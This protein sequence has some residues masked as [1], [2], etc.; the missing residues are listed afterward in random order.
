MTEGF[1]SLKLSPVP[2]ALR[3]VLGLLP[4]LCIVLRIRG[5]RCSAGLLWGILSG[6]G[7]IVGRVQL[8]DLVC[9]SSSAAVPLFIGADFHMAHAGLAAHL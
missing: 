3:G 7:L 4:R 2:A 1:H 6:L 5:L 9:L 8:V